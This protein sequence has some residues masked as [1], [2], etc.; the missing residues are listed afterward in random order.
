MASNTYTK[1]E[2]TGG[3]DALDGI[4]GDT[5]SAI[6]AKSCALVLCVSAICFS[7]YLFGN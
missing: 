7:F 3:T 2:L 4:D 6:K 5:L 1:K